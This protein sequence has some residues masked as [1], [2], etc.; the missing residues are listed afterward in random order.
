MDVDLQLRPGLT[1]PDVVGAVLALIGRA[2]E[3]TGSTFARPRE[4]AR[5]ERQQRHCCDRYCAR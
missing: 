2:L 1:T 5:E 4:R 3:G